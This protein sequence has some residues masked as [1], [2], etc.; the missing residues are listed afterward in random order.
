MT[1]GTWETS[2][3]VTIHCQMETADAQEGNSKCSVSCYK[4]CLFVWGDDTRDKIRNYPCSPKSSMQQRV[5][6]G[7]PEQ[8]SKKMVVI[9]LRFELLN[10]L[11]GKSS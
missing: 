1:S 5:L 7:L 9:Y 6:P 11:S 8:F 3:T 4:F 2:K 10:S